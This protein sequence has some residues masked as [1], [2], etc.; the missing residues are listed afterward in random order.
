LPV[1]M[2]DALAGCRPRLIKIAGPVIHQRSVARNFTSGTMP[3]TSP[4]L[5]FVFCDLW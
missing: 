2:F 5:P 4:G 3:L 1:S